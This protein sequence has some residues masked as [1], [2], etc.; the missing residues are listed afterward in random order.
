[1]TQLFAFRSYKTSGL[2]LE[3]IFYRALKHISLVKYDYILSFN[4]D[5]FI[6]MSAY[7]HICLNLN[8]QVKCHCLV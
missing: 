1:M 6:I 2:Y 8:V 5:F 3:K 4:L 7:Q